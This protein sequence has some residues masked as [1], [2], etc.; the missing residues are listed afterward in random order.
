MQTLD[1]LVQDVEQGQNITDAADIISPLID[2]ETASDAIFNFENDQVCDSSYLTKLKNDFKNTYDNMDESKKWR[3]STGKCVEDEIYCFGM[4]CSVEHQT[5]SFIIDTNDKNWMD[6]AVFSKNELDEINL[7]NQKHT[8]IMSK[9]LRDYLNQYNKTT[10]SD[11]RKEVFKQMEMDENF[12]PK[13]HFDYDWI[14]NTCYNLLM[15][16]E[17]GSLQTSH[18]EEWYK[19]HV[20]NFN[21][22]VFNHSNIE[23]AR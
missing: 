3:L 21:D 12:N 2:Q 1:D 23:V 22:T 6:Y 15:E 10:T 18:N 5:H 19:A 8:P 14:R 16:F 17:A 13:E 11:I 4:Q 9:P 7:Y 20:W